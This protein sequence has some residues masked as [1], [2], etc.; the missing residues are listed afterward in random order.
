MREIPVNLHARKHG[1]SE[2][3]CEGGATPA[4]AEAYA[5]EI[6]VP[7]DWRWPLPGSV[8]AEFS[9]RGVEPEF[10]VLAN[11]VLNRTQ[12]GIQLERWLWKMHEAGVS[13]DYLEQCG[14]RR[15]EPEII[16]EGW[17]NGLPFEY[18]AEL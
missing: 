9:E 1:V 4:V 14:D 5:A 10:M 15:I 13:I 2:E 17:V 3:L 18:M 16:V 12:W 11:R 7:Q 8:V 6:R